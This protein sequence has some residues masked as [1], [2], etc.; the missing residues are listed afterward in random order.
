M[1]NVT[2]F[3]E[4]YEAEN[5]MLG[6]INELIVRYNGRMTNVAMLGILQAS[7]NFIFLSIANDMEGDE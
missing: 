4:K 1:T 2:Q 7:S 6:D 5:N 3:P